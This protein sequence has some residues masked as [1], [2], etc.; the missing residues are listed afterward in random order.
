MLTIRALFILLAV[1]CG[2]NTAWGQQLL[3]TNPDSLE[4]MFEKYRFITIL[5]GAGH[6]Q[7]NSI[8]NRMVNAFLRNS[9]IDDDLKNEQN[10]QDENNL[11]GAG[12]HVGI[13][14]FVSMKKLLGSTRYGLVLSASFHQDLSVRF[15]RDLF[16]LTFYGNSNYAGQFADVSNTGFRFVSTA[17]ASMGF[18]EKRTMSYVTVGVIGGNQFIDLE[19]AQSGIYTAEDGSYIGANLDGRLIVSDTSGAANLKGVGGVINFE[20]NMPIRFASR[21]DKP[22]WLRVGG[23]NVGLMNWNEQTLHYRADSSYQY[24]GFLIDDLAGFNNIEDQLDNVVDSLLPG[25]ERRNFLLT[26]PGWLYVSWFSPLGEKLYYDVTLRSRINAFHLPEA[27]VGLTYKSGAKW[28][29]GANLTYGGYGSLNGMDGLRAGITGSTMVGEHFMVQL[30][31]T[32]V[33]GW[34]NGQ[35]RGRNLWLRLMMFF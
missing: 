5:D 4:R 1:V 14:Q 12:Y 32:H 34:F 17:Q 6:Q 30:E 7:S 20:V 11:M 8:N 3:L 13:M 28:M 16:N 19:T 22:S 10:L 24:E 35:A 23:R 33:S 21:P 27:T 2:L 18:Y 29:A 31:S 9:F 15:N 25:A 26:T